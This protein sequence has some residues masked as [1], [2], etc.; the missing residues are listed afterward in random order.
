MALP[1]PFSFATI[2]SATPSP[3]RPTF[4]KNPST[5][6]EVLQSYA[7]EIYGLMSSKLQEHGRSPLPKV[8]SPITPPS[9]ELPRSPTCPISHPLND[10]KYLTMA[11]RIAGYYQQRAQAVANY[12]HQK[13]KEW[14]SLQQQK[15]REMTQVTMLVV[16]W[17][18]RDRISRRRRRQKKQFNRALS[19]R[20]A[21]SKV[22]KGES[23]RRWAMNIPADT[24]SPT[25]QASEAF[26]DVAEAD[27]DM[28]KETLPD[29]DTEMFR[30]AD[31]L[32]RSQLAR[33][34][35]P[36]FGALSFDES[37][38]EVEEDEDEFVDY[39]DDEDMYDDVDD[40]DE[41]EDEDEPVSEDKAPEKK[42]GNGGEDEH[43]STKEEAPSDEVH[44][45][46]GK[47]SRKYR[48][49]SS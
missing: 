38:E 49:T 16:A 37:E 5:S 9:P 24:A 19:K 8:S 22:N 40:E 27:F 31:H 46:S 43:P 3:D 47:A 18:V 17:Y 42:A 30:V 35:V 32:I 10:P 33:I 25:S 2:L 44:V 23:V 48:S 7:Q 41:D 36:L 15:T 21:M 29:R 11:S 14:A 34:D 39:D 28:D 6:S 12:Q 4:S 20:A 1:N 26:A 13:C 45:G